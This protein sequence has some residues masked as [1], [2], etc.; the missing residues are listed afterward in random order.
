MAD[1]VIVKETT[2]EELKETNETNKHQLSPYRSKADSSL[3][4]FHCFCRELVAC[5]S[6]TSTSTSTSTSK[7][8]LKFKTHTYAESEENTRKVLQPLAGIHPI[9]L[10][11]T[12]ILEPVVA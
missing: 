4:L 5:L 3:F 1:F 6:S 11:A 10:F 9:S 8:A 7:L 2:V 12:R